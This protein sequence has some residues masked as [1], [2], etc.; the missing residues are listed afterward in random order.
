MANEHTKGPWGLLPCSHGGLILTRD[1]CRQSHV[2]IIPEADARLMAAAPD[3]LA[4]CTDL[5]QS[6]VCCKPSLIDAIERA[7]IK[8]TGGNSGK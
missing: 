5:L 4:A 8:A 2:Q 1:G 7:V 6:A 3:L